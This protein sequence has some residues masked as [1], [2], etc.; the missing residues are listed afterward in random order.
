M[1]RNVAEDRTQVEVQIQVD[2]YEWALGR[3]TAV[4]YLSSTKAAR[5]LNVQDALETSASGKRFWEP[6]VAN[7]PTSFRVH[8]FHTT[9]ITAFREH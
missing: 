8:T 7:G 9:Y 5:P 1:N 4:G 3:M 2:Q 6:A